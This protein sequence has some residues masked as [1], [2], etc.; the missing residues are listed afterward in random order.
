MVIISGNDILYNMLMSYDTTKLEEKQS[1]ICCYLYRDGPQTRV[2]V[3]M[4]LVYK[5]SFIP[6]FLNSADR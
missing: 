2:T 6:N 3:C 5:I 1:R 4:E